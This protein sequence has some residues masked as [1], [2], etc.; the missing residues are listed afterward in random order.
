MTTTNK[1]AP[2]NPRLGALL[3][4]V[5]RGNIKIPAFQREYVW[6]DDQIMSLLD[7]IYHGYPVGSLLL[8]STKVALKHERDVGGFALPETAEDFPVN[9]L[10]D[11]QQRLTTLFGVFNSDAK[12]KDPQLA[13][14][15][16]VSFVPAS[17]QFMHS[18]VADAKASINLRTILDTTKLL[19]ELGRFTADEQKTIATLTERFKDYEFP[20]V[21]IRDR[22]NQE[23]CRVFQRI[24]SSGTSLSTLELLSAWTWS[25]HFNLV[26]EINSLLEKLEDSNYGDLSEELVLRCLAAVVLGKIDADELVDV[27]PNDLVGGMAK[28]QQAVFAAV[29]FLEKELRIKNIVFVPFPIMFVPLVGFFSRNLKPTAAQLVAIKRWFWHCAFTQKYKAGTNTAILEDLKKMEQLVVD[30]TVFDGLTAKVDVDLFKKTWRIN[31]TAAKA[32]ICM[33]AQKE[34]RSFLNGALVD[35]GTAMSAYN[36]RE[37]HHIYPKAHLATQ[38]ILFHQS[39]IIANICLLSSSDNRTI[40]DASPVIYMPNIPAAQKDQIAD[41]ALIPRDMFDGTKSYT[42][43]VTARAALLAAT[44]ESLIHKGSP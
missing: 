10:L 32:A 2:S 23:V 43:F 22:S 26:N 38:S 6:K 12:T 37:F 17:G 1:I 14:R 28:L 39:N 9:Y 16:D 34:P 18:S 3:S 29:D 30:N 31:S 36:A 8:W 40:S 25:D 41:G 4:D 33:L 19:P 21:T 42:D 20:V 27:A 11:G 44:A 35:L 5:S 7:S 13:S 24:N 15:F